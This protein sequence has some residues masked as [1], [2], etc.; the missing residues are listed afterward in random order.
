MLQ[1]RLT[2]KCN[3]LTEQVLLAGILDR[4]IAGID[5]EARLRSLGRQ[6]VVRSTGVPDDQVAWLCTNLHP[7][8]AVLLQPFETCFFEPVPLIGPLMNSFLVRGGTVIVLTKEVRTFAD[9]QST[10]IWPVR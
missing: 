8:A 6:V 1:F 7:F 4:H 5:A 10:I 3:F 2:V 9:N